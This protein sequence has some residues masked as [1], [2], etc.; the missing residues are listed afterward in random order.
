MATLHH[1]VETIGRVFG[2]RRQAIE[3]VATEFVGPL[4]ARAGAEAAAALI[5]SATTDELTHPIRTMQRL[6]EFRFDGAMRFHG[7]EAE[8]IAHGFQEAVPDLPTAVAF[9]LEIAASRYDTGVRSG[10]VQIDAARGEATVEIIL[11]GGKRVVL[12]Y[13]LQLRMSAS[14]RMVARTLR[15]SRP[16]LEVVADALNVPQPPSG[17]EAGECIELHRAA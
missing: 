6:A 8:H 9:A 3:W 15:I 10:D 2:I 13:R 12:E 14:V 17:G 1:I 11:G 7:S 5:L 16:H 4:D